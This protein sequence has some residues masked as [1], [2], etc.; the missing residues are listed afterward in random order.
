[1]QVPV[2]RALPSSSAK[3]RRSISLIKGTLSGVLFFVLGRGYWPMANTP[4]TR[5]IGRWPIRAR[6]FVLQ[7]GIDFPAA[8]HTREV[9]FHHAGCGFVLEKLI[10][11]MGLF[12]IVNIVDTSTLDVF[13]VLQAREVNA[14]LQT[15]D[16][17][18]M[19]CTA[20]IKGFV[21]ILIV[22]FEG[23]PF[24][25]VTGSELIGTSSCP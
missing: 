17:G 1:M 22:R 24:T 3:Y 20:G 9:I 4:R 18:L 5:A 13:G 11:P 6:L 2:L 15:A 12:C 25:F 8:V 7:V 21:T 19:G 14:R 23:I 10:Y 16:M